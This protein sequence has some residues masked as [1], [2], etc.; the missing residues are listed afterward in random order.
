VDPIRVAIVG[1]GLAGRHFHAPLIAATA[2]LEVSYLVTANDVRRRQAEVE[3]PA[4]RILPSLDELWEQPAPPELVVVATTNESHVPLATAAIAHGVAVVVDKPLAI[5]AP[6][7]E[8]LVH[9]AERARVPLTVF[10]NRRWDTDQLTLRRL[11]AE[12]ALGSVVRY[13]SRFER[14]RP[15]TDPSKWR[16]SAPPERGGGVLLDLGT[17][18]VD[19]AIVLLGA[20]T[21]VYAEIRSLRG[22][23]ADDDAF[24]AL[25]HPGGAISHLWVSAAAPAPGPRLR[26][27]GTT[28]GFLVASLDPQEAALRV[29]ARPDADDGWGKPP[30][31]E[32]GRL[33]AGEHSI[34][35]RPEP[36]DWPRFYAMLR[37]AL[38]AGGPLPVDPRDAIRTLRVLDAARRSARSGGVVE[39]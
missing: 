32:H 13:E 7:A 23:P 11:L 21:H 27:Q 33:V 30:V 12:D 31:F 24:I 25:R 2:G 20:P 3:H 6:E 19:Q 18:L 29:G 14:W 8:A 5:N 36:G 34:P 9:M 26:V 16:E 38:G 39:M 15:D 17:H 4:A 37:D 28:G 35:V 1:Y 22:A 10:H